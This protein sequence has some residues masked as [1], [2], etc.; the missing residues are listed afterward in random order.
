MIMP[1]R[2]L[3]RNARPIPPALEYIEIIVIPLA[4]RTRSRGALED[5]LAHIALGMR[6]AAQSR[7]A[8][9]PRT[10]SFAGAHIR[11]KGRERGLPLCVRMAIATLANSELKP[12]CYD[13]SACQTPVRAYRRPGA[14]CWLGI[15]RP[16]HL[17]WRLS[18][19]ILLMKSYFIAAEPHSSRE[20]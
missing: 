5:Q 7:V 9:G 18:W 14:R 16:L 3:Y 4:G 13:W 19:P 10:P 6:K 12:P 20:L 2:P 8:R 15:G 17:E 11:G 1:C